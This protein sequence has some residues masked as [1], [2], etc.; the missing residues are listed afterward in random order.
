VGCFARTT[1]GVLAER[2]LTASV[3]LNAA[4]PAG[5]VSGGAVASILD[6]GGIMTKRIIYSKP[7]RTKD[8]PNESWEFAETPSGMFYYFCRLL[9]VEKREK[10]ES[11]STPVQQAQAKKSPA[12][13]SPAPAAKSSES[14]SERL[15]HFLDG[16]A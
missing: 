10:P 15:R 8:D 11:S 4:P 2:A 3:S 5:F 14:L 1:A 7:D 13:S 9:D 12:A 16:D 6:E